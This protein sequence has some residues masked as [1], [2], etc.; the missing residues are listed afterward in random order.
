MPSITFF[1][2]HSKTYRARG[3]S[4]HYF[5]RFDQKL[6]NGV[7]AIC[8]IPYACVACTSMVYKHWVSGI[9]SDKKERYKP[10]TNCAYWSVLWPLNNCIIIQLSHKSTPFD[11]FDE[12]HQ[13]VLYGI[14]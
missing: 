2:A 4:K 10:V 13:G 7:Y 9:P 8:C 5:L 6:G 11:A 12:L 14:S 1:G 3:L